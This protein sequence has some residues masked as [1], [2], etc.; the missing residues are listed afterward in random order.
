MPPGIAGNIKPCP[1]QQNRLK[2]N[3][4]KTLLIVAVNNL[5]ENSGTLETYRSEFLAAGDFS[6]RTGGAFPA[7]QV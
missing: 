6:R 4:C 1:E 2:S 7:R 3:L 5:P